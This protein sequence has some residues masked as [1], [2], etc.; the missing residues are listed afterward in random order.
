MTPANPSHFLD[1]SDCILLTRRLAELSRVDRAAKAAGFKDLVH[2]LREYRAA[3]GPWET[4]TVFQCATSLFEVNLADSTLSG[5][6]ADI[7]F[8]ALVTYPW[9]DLSGPADRLAWASQFVM[10]GILLQ[11]FVGSLDTIAATVGMRLLDHLHAEALLQGLHR[12]LDLEAGIINA[13]DRRAEL[14]GLCERAYTAVFTLGGGATVFSS[15]R[16]SVLTYLAFVVD[17]GRDGATP[18]GLA[19]KGVLP[20]LYMSAIHVLPSN[21]AHLAEDPI[22]DFRRDDAR[23]PHELAVPPPTGPDAPRTLTH[24]ALDLDDAEAVFLNVVGNQRYRPELAAGGSSAEYIE[25][26]LHPSEH[27][28]LIRDILEADPALAPKKS[29][30]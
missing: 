18:A 19:F 6:G 1:R 22:G 27:D 13:A 29:G 26:P 24:P 10:K 8:D 23:P 21:T 3:R 5:T 14:R 12:R 11:P 4:W 28:Q 2:K 17:L 25:V 7:I 20:G 30:A 16:G 15:P 9:S